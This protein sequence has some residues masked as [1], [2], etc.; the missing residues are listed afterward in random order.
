[1]AHNPETVLVTGGA[2][3]IGSH[4]ALNLKNKGYK[5]IVLDDLSGGTESFVTEILQVPF[6]RSSVTDS[7]SVEAAIRKFEI[8]SVMHFAGFIQVGES[9]KDPLKYYSNNTAASLKFIQTV[10][11]CGIRNF[12]FSST[13]AVYGQPVS[14][15]ISEEHP[16]Q[17]INPYGWSKLMTE[18]M[19]RDLSAAS[20]FRYMVFR[21]FNAA[22]ADSDSGLGENHSPETHLI[23][24]I[25]EAALGLRTH[26]SVFGTDYDTPDG[27][28]IRDYIHVNDLAEAHASGLAAL[29][30]GK[31]SSVYNL[32][33]GSG[34]SVREVIEAAKR[35][36]GREF[37]VRN[38]ERRAGDPARL[39]SSSRRVREDLSWNPQYP[40]AE[41]IIEHAWKYLLYKHRKQIPGNVRV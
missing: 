7:E 28:C 5:V 3:Y 34:F 23:P 1:M 12:V 4:A 11:R 38:E 29:I 22:G 14:D 41:T 35:V 30:S 10:Y 15:V 18:Q 16:L 6:I 31:K 26:I 9:V 20:D 36:T 21:Y 19:L 17:P 2:G 13:A 33:N 25:L 37:E 39:V 40:D 8:G 27:T 24:L 32:G